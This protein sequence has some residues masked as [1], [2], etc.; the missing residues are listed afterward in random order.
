MRG[1]LQFAIVDEYG[2]KQILYSEVQEF[3]AE[4]C[5]KKDYS[6][7]NI[8]DVSISCDVELTKEGKEFFEQQFLQAS[9]EHIEKILSEMNKFNVRKLTYRL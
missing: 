6:L 7:A 9:A 2:T 3:K 1:E 5:N 8:E 4:L